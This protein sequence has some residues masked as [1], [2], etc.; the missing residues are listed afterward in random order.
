MSDS[1][2]FYP[3]GKNVG[4]YVPLLFAWFFSLLKLKKK[5]EDIFILIYNKITENLE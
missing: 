3:W 5:I 4:L 2:N 1:L